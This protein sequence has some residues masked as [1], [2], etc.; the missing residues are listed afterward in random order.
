MRAARDALTTRG[1]AFVAA[2]VVLLGSGIGLG[3]HDLTRIGLLLLGLP[4]A[5]A[6]FGYRHDLSLEV[7]R[8]ASP[9]GSGSTSPPMSS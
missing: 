4:L 2:G 3:Q 5:S 6:L 7:S 1:M 8:V 9:A